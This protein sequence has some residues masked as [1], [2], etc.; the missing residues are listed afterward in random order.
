[1]LLWLRVR[2]QDAPYGIVRAIGRYLPMCA[3]SASKT[4]LIVEDDIDTREFYELLLM[5]AGYQV[6]S[7]R[8]GQRAR[9]LV[10][11]QPVDGVL[12]DY[13]LP[14]T[15]G[16]ELCRELR[17]ALGPAVPILLVTADHDPTLMSRAIAAGATAFLSKPFDP[18]VLLALFTAHMPGAAPT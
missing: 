13:R 7:V 6:V 15:I 8:T 12:L 18:N 4:I 14:F 5:S 17:A 16:V 10:A 9:A 2:A 3:Q 1:M 11:R